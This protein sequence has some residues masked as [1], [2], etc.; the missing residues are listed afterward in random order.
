M[1]RAAIQAACEA[2]E[3]PAAMPCAAVRQT[4]LGERRKFFGVPHLYALRRPGVGEH[5]AVDVPLRIL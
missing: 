5:F 3:L 2:L 1:E 4:E